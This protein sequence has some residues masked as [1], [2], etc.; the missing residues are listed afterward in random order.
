VEIT[1]DAPGA[2]HDTALVLVD[3]L[4][5]RRRRE[6]QSWVRAGGTLFVADPASP[7]APW[8]RAGTTDVGLFPADIEKRC[9]LPALRGV[10]RVSVDGGSVFDAPAGVARC[11]PRNDGWWLVAAAVGEGNVVAVGGAGP[12]VNRHLDEADNAAVIAAV[13]APR[14]GAGVAFL[15][16]PPP[17]A[18][19]RRSLVSLISP[20]VK[21]AGW[22]LGIAF[23]VLALWRARRLGRPVVEPQP[24]QLEASELVV[25]V[26]EL[27]QRS[28]S[29]ERA[30]DLLRDDL[31]RD[32][33]DADARLGDARVPRDDAALVELAQRI[34]EIREEVTRVP[35]T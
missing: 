30:A 35:V 12:F 29:R 26:G 7:L 20:R 28:G 10:G 4:G 9:E 19:G 5:D 1:R 16:P 14:P 21:A 2:G 18:G 25:A 13:L 11:Y 33:P 27:L 22:Q 15:R 23:A 34:E 6:V 24:V 8:S 3:D 17:G 32:V 31:R